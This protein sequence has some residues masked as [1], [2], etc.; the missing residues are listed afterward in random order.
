MN[1]NYYLLLNREL[2]RYTNSNPLLLLLMESLA[3]SS[4]GFLHSF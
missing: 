1:G 2:Q 3:L 4:K